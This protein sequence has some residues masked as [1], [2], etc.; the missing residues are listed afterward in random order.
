MNGAADRDP[1]DHVTAARQRR[2]VAADEVR[3]VMW[4]KAGIDRSARGLR[5]CLDALDAIESRLPVGA[6]EEANLIATGRLI[7][8]AA[9]IRSESRGGHFRTDFSERDVNWEVHSI[10]K[11]G[12]EISRSEKI[13]F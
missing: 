3:R 9:L 7:A 5:K 2:V 8:G 1:H 13:N 6:T 4:E 11:L 10:Q 12:A